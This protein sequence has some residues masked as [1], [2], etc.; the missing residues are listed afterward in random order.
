MTILTRVRWVRLARALAKQE[1]GRH[2]KWLSNKISR[3]SSFEEGCSR[4]VAKASIC[5]LESWCISELC[6]FNSFNSDA[7]FARLVGGSDEM[8]TSFSMSLPSPMVTAST[9]DS[10][11]ALR[12][13]RVSRQP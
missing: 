4:L 7:S 3:L 5:W 12:C 2:I 11:T 6:R 8:S 9:F 13:L 1:G 10:R